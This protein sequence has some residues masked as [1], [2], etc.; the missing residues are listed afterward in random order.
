MCSGVWNSKA[1]LK[2]FGLWH[3]SCFLIFICVFILRCHTPSKGKYCAILRNT[4]VV[5]VVVVGPCCSSKKRCRRNVPTSKAPLQ[6]RR[7]LLLSFT[8]R[9]LCLCFRRSWPCFPAWPI[10]LRLR[11]H[12]S[13]LGKRP[14]PFVFRGESTLQRCC[15]HTSLVCFDCVLGNIFGN[16]LSLEPV[17]AVDLPSSQT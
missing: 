4:L 3:I 10:L 11:K 2:V 9:Q 7:K 5:F 6:P 12:V 8:W 17:I 15:P 14:C 1:V 16:I 13:F